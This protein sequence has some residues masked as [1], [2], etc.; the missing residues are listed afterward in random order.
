M[1]RDAQD[2]FIEA[3]IF[4]AV[5]VVSITGTVWALIY[6]LPYLIR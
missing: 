5:V 6:L 4:L 2:A 1:I 3:L